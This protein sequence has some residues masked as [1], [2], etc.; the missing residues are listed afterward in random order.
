MNELANERTNA[1]SRRDYS[2]KVPTS[3]WSLDVQGPH[4]TTQ[5]PHS[6]LLRRLSLGVFVCPS[7]PH[8]QWSQMCTPAGRLN[9]QTGCLCWRPGYLL[10]RETPL[11]DVH[12]CQILWGALPSWKSLAT[13][14]SGTVQAAPD[15]LLRTFLCCEISFSGGTGCHGK[16]EMPN[17][18]S[19]LGVGWAVLKPCDAPLP[20]GSLEEGPSPS[21]ECV[22]SC[23]RFRSIPH[24]RNFRW[25]SL[26]S[27]D[28]KLWFPL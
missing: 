15:G 1:C 26:Y 4:E 6:P 25:N 9:L 3:L 28:S 18:C 11:G 8:P 16:S 5:K 19:P 7:F 21:W 12:S 23:P 10:P 22:M 2:I 13:L 20:P 17:S 27:W 14:G 24:L